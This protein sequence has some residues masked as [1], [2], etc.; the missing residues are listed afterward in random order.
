[1]VFSDCNLGTQEVEQENCEFKA[2]L[3]CT[4]RALSNKTKLSKNING[5]FLTNK[6]F[7]YF[8]SAS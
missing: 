5:E 7:N 3:D 4:V 8:F 2:S 1:M 6:H